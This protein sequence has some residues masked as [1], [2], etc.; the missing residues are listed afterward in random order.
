MK[1]IT[2]LLLGLLMMTSASAAEY[3]YVPLVR[4]GVVWEYVGYESWVGP[5]PIS[6]GTQLYTLEFNGTTEI[7]DCYG[8][9][10]TFYNLYRTDF[11]KGGEALVPCIAAYVKEENRVVTAIDIDLN[12]WWSVPDTV[13]N[14]NK[15]FFLPDMAFE[16]SP[17]QDM[18]NYMS[19]V[20]N[21]AGTI[22]EGYHINYYIDNEM[23]IIEGI[24]VDCNYGDL[25]IPFR[26]YATGNNPMAGLS[27]V[28][29]N[30]ELVYKGCMYDVAQRL[31]H[32]KEDV[33]GDGHVT[34]ADV[35]LI[36]NFLLGYSSKKTT[37]YDVNG[38]GEVTSADITAIYNVILGEQ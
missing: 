10:N 27:A 30:G 8:Q 12:Y 36:Y 19:I 33:D 16:V 34:S 7:N 23:K 35:T 14:F 4:E 24:G 21:V 5:N 29:E 3:E 17:L 15:L 2:F 1:K 31:K 32:K 6:E 37:S 28:Y 38:D 20:I 11:E 13:Y 22:R 25:L 9:T 18:N 26:V